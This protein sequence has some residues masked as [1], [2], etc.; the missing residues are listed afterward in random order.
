MKNKSLI[1]EARAKFPEAGSDLNALNKFAAN[2]FEQL[3]FHQD[4][5]SKEFQDLSFKYHLV[6]AAYKAEFDRIIE[7]SSHRMI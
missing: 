5:D 2:I 1:E 7:Q 4:K 6:R 3:E